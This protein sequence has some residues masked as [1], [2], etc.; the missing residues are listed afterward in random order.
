MRTLFSKQLAKGGIIDVEAE[1]KK[2]LVTTNQSDDT[3][4]LP[5]NDS[6][7]SS[8]CSR[9]VEEKVKGDP[10]KKEVDEEELEPSGSRRRWQPGG[11]RPRGHYSH[12]DRHR[13]RRSRPDY[14]CKRN[15]EEASQDSTNGCPKDAQK[16]GER[17]VNNPS[18][19][20]KRLG[21]GRGRGRGAS[22]QLSAL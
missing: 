17:E 5:R 7:S 14:H 12:M 1:S 4:D 16:V 10:V 13:N 15:K 21:K 18:S 2:F 8:L 6:S 9:A 3:G 19:S 20:R 11:G 22:H